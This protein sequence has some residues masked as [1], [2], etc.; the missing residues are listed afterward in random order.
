MIIS[1]TP[2]QRERISQAALQGLRTLEKP[3]PLR[4]SE[5]ADQHFY[6]SAESSYVEGRWETLPYQRSIMDCISND[7]IREI[8][9]IKSARVGY[10]KLVLAAIGYFAEHKHRNQAVWQPVDDDAD[11]FVKTELDP[12][13]RDVAVVQ[14]VFPSYNRKSRDNTLRQKMFLGSALHVRGG[15]AAKNY[16]RIS[17]DV[18]Y[19]DELDGFD[20]DVEREGD[21]VTL[22]S[23][24][25]EGS[26]FPKV[27]LGSTPKIKG[28]SLIDARVENAEIFLRFYIPCPHCGHRQHLRWG[29]KDEDFGFK[30]ADNKPET[31]AYLC[32]ACSALFTQDEYLGIWHHGRYQSDDGIYI[33]PEGLFRDSQDNLLDTPLSVAFHVWTAYSPMASWTQIVREFLA[34]RKDRGKLKTFV[35][36]TLGESWE[37]DE[38]E[39]IEHT[40]LFYRREHYKAPVPEG[41]VV[42]TAGV[43]TQDDRFEIQIDGWGPGEERWT[44]DYIRLFGDP[45]R[46]GIWDKLLE[47]LKRSYLREDNTIMNIRLACQDHGGHYADEVNKFSKRAWTRFLIP[48]KGSS[49]YGRPVATFPRKRNDKGVYLT[50]VGTDTA[51]DL[52]YQRLLIQQPGPGYWHWPVLDAFDEEYFKQLTNEQRELKWVKGKRMFIWDSKGKRQEPWDCS[53]YSLA[54]VRIL[55]QHFGLRLETHRPMAGPVAHPKPKPAAPIAHGKSLG[56]SEWASKL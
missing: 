25:V 10:T 13:L 50:A 46:Q 19:L 27:I 34:A 6:L 18:V 9:L 4:L 17:V 2:E 28:E 45:S 22:A 53:V 54:A 24:R 30:W 43:D 21:P 5:W 52:L 39:K 16:R 49:V 31:A 8:S 12:M 44:V 38:S 29:G 20:S 15:R 26:T 37:E 36:T 14:L 55:Q 48:I 1:L 23:K 7:D 40:A 47:A 11:E 33:D 56:L 41:V 3:E 42:L 51:K 32:E 35:N